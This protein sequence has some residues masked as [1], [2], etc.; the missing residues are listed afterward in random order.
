[1][2]S[3]KL[4]N[5]S[6]MFRKNSSIGS[7]DAIEDTN[8]LHE[9]FVDTGDLEI[10]RDTGK[11]QCIAVGRTGAGKTALLEYLKKSEDHV[12]KIDV[13]NLA[14]NY[15]SND[16]VIKYF[17]DL[18]I[19]LD[20][21][22][23]LLWRHILAVEVIRKNQEIHDESANKNFIAGMRQKFAKQGRKLEAFNYFA[24]WN[25]SF[26][27][28]TDEQLQGITRNTAKELGTAAKAAVGIDVN[29]LSSG[30]QLAS[31]RKETITEEQKVLISKRG[32][33]VI[34]RVQI[35]KLSRIL[36]IIDE[37]LLSDPQ[38]PYYITIDRLDED[39]VDSQLRYKLIRALLETVRDFN[40][41][42]K[43]LKIIIALREDL[44]DR[45]FQQTRSS[46]QQEEKYKSMNL[47]VGWKKSQLIDLIDKR[48]NLMIREKYTSQKVD[49]KSILPNKVTRKEEDPTD[50]MITRTMMRPRDII[51]FFNDCI[52]AAEGKAKISKQNLLEAEE[53][54]SL[55]RLR[56]LADEWSSDYP[57]LIKLSLCMK[58]FPKKFKHNEVKVLEIF[59]AN[60]LEFLSSDTVE[61]D[62]IYFMCQE[63]FN[64]SQILSLLDE[65][66]KIL[67]RVGA[68][69]VKSE[70]YN[71]P[72]WSYLGQKV[73]STNDESIFYVHPMFWRVLGVKP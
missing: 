56:A 27:K 42:V 46:G 22:Y 71:H 17:E 44:I 50:Y 6:F 40:A 52:E 3:P 72:H 5:S 32:Q 62:H 36:N 61:K 26:W 41:K 15:I 30:F 13:S 73:L 57:N 51:M 23:K 45:V 53:K 60:V 58:K 39:W 33:E 68:I 28:D 35:A 54:Y 2:K 14:L 55:D 31:N 64:A 43:N 9:A 10:L 29:D 1:M 59:E 16:T 38:K 63:K 11:P 66:L 20:P 21:F 34:N 70:S 37:D 12:I 48:V 25:S 65:S 47:R 8:Y 49:L 69:G 4:K 24:K 18:G 19:N 67:F 7:A